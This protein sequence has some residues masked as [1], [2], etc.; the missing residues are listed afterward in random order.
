[1]Q[2]FGSITLSLQ[3]KVGDICTNACHIHVTVQV[4]KD[5]TC[6]TLYVTCHGPLKKILTC[7]IRVTPPLK[8]PKTCHTQKKKRDMSRNVLSHSCHGTRIW[9]NV[10]LSV[11]CHTR[12]DI[13]LFQKFQPFVFFSLLNY[14]DLPMK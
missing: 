12:C 7:H 4:Y 3:K 5:V 8:Y 2:R 9:H 1:M 14:K 11:T 13:L 10:T 6:H